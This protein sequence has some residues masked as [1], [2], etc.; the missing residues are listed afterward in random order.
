MV[1]SHTLQVSAAGGSGRTA[2]CGVGPSVPVGASAASHPEF[3]GA[4]V[5]H[6][7]RAARCGVGSPSW[8]GGCATS[9]GRTASCGAASCRS[10]AIIPPQSP[11]TVLM[12]SRSLPQCGPG[13]ALA[14]MLSYF[15]CC[16]IG[17][18]GLLCR[19]RQR[20]CQRGGGALVPELR[21]AGFVAAVAHG[22]LPAVYRRRQGFTCGVGADTSSPGQRP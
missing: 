22:A 9:A 21:H 13:H 17:R 7:P 10:S 18:A 5:V 4:V 2:S 15:A 19:R 8:A 6:P 20:R 12:M 1:P 14:T 11:Q 16:R 3:C